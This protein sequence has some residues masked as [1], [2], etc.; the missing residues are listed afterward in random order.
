MRALMRRYFASKDWRDLWTMT[1]IYAVL[2]HLIKAGATVF[3][4]VELANSYS[5]MIAMVIIITWRW[6]MKRALKKLPPELPG[7]PGD[8][9]GPGSTSTS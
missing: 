5:G 2:V 4:T 8:S 1:I 9:G 6:A 3:L 7:T